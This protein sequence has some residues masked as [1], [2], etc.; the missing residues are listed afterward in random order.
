MKRGDK[1]RTPNG[2]IETVMET[3]DCQVFTY[4]SEGRWYHPT[5]VFQVWFSTTLKKYVTIPQ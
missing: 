5:K 2:K 4:E 3:N 1:I